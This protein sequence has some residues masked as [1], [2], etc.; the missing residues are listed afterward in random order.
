MNITYSPSNRERISE[1]RTATMKPQFG[2]RAQKAAHWLFLNRCPLCL[3]G[4]GMAPIAALCLTIFGL[5]SLRVATLAV[6]FPAVLIV[7]VI[8]ARSAA[9]GRIA[10][11]GFSVG[12]VA[13]LAYDVFRLWFVC[14]GWWGDFIPNIGGWLLGSDHPNALLGY[15]WRWAGNGGGMGMTCVVGYALAFRGRRT[16]LK[17]MAFCTGFGIVIWGCLILTLLASARGQAMLFKIT[18][19]TLAL[20]LIGHLVYGACIGLCNGKLKRPTN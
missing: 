12:L 4:C 5:W 16:F 13:V 17:S 6:V 1:N 14:Q 19:L 11:I 8:V 3:M 7:A 9:A 2:G 18:P 10:L 20:S 15:V